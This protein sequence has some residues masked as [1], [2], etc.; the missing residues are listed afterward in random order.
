MHIKKLSTWFLITAALV[1]PVGA[2]TP[3]IFWASDPVG[4]DETVLVQGSEFAGA[5]V[6][7]SRLAMLP[8][9]RGCG[10]G[11]MMQKNNN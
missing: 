5:K 6:E 3:H 4:P 1:L 9:A 2:E 7:L 8:L 10:G 11:G